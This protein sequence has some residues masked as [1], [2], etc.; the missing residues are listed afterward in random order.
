MNNV[1][2]ELEANDS[3]MSN[4]ELKKV[5]DRFK[6]G[7]SNVLIATSVIE[8]GLDVTQCNLVIRMN[9]LL[10]VKSFVQMRGRAR[11]ACSKF[12]FL[13]AEQE[14]PSVQEESK[15]FHDII[16]IMNE[17]VQTVRLAPSENIFEI[18]RP[19]EEDYLDIEGGA[20]LHA[21]AA[22]VVLRH[23]IDVAAECYKRRTREQR[24]AESQVKISNSVK[25]LEPNFRHTE[26]E[27]YNQ[28]YFYSC[29]YLPRVVGPYVNY[30]FKVLPR[31]G[32][33]KK[34]HG[35][36]HVCQL[37]V[38]RIYEHGYFDRFLVPTIGL[39]SKSSLPRVVVQQPKAKKEQ[40]PKVTVS[41]VV[42]QVPEKVHEKAAQA[43]QR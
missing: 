11:T 8:E 43:N 17:S 42:V 14:L 19:T 23:F 40:K 39:K 31:Q 20:R 12:I 4:A 34:Q 27:E 35:G 37:A 25:D 26:H 3:G 13:A 33:Q 9:E 5:I 22:P 1:S 30:D 24:E 36:D 28:K 38:R 29:L 32:F 2:Q 16:K 7:T 21:S 6:Q 15:N 10:N 41:K 18:K